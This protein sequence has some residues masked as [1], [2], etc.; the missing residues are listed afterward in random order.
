MSRLAG[1]TTAAAAA[2]AGVQSQ[3]ASYGA[4]PTPQQVTTVTGS[5]VDSLELYQSVLAATPAPAT[6]TKAV[7]ALDSQL[8]SDIASFG[9]AGTV[10]RAQLGQFLDLLSLRVAGLHARLTTLQHTIDPMAKSGGS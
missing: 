10:T 3:L 1:A 9:T 4:L 2:T 7:R 5:Y 6:A 8:R